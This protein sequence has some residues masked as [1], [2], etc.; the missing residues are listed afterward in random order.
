MSKIALILPGHIEKLQDNIVEFIHN[1]DC[2]VYIHTWNTEENKRWL[3][4]LRGVDTNIEV[5]D[6]SELPKKFSILHS[7]YRA[8]NLIKDLEEYDLIIKGKPDLDIDSIAFDSNVKQYYKEAYKHSYPLLKGVKYSDC[9]FGRILHETIDERFFSAHPL[10]FKKLFRIL[11]NKYI[12]NIY[13]LDKV[14]IKKYGDQYEGSI[15]WTELI[16]QQ[17]IKLIQDLTLKIPNCI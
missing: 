14:L 16:K 8:V 5:Q 7:T 3:G 10:V 11:Y 17:E 4:K 6:L 2:D 1:N 15:L 9:I 12:D 13:S